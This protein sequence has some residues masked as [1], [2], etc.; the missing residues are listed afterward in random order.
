MIQVVYSTEEMEP[1]NRDVFSK[2]MLKRYHQFEKYKKI[3]IDCIYGLI[4]GSS[5]PQGELFNFNFLSYKNYKC[6]LQ[7]VEVE[8]VSFT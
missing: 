3:K 5:P 7:D 8:G 2:L 4:M 1:I 6:E